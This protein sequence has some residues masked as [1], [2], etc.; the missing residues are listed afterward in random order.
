MLD[1]IASVNNVTG[2]VN[3]DEDIKMNISYTFSERFIRIISNVRCYSNFNES[4]F[5]SNFKE[6]SIFR[7][8][9]LVMFIFKRKINSYFFK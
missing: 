3:V 5:R 8:I 9:Y 4:Y 2:Y 1:E 7:E 6:K